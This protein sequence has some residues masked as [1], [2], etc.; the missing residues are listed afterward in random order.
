M[1]EDEINHGK[2][3]PDHIRQ[4]SI[5]EFAKKLVDRV[6]SEGEVELSELTDY[7]YNKYRSKV[8]SEQSMKQRISTTMSEIIESD[9]YK[10]N[11]EYRT[12]DGLI[13]KRVFIHED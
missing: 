11:H 1:A 8:T 12:G 13:K 6:K 5:D 9:D 7:M 3:T 4:S 10:I 2:Y